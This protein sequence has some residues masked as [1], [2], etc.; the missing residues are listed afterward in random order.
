MAVELEVLWMQLGQ[1]PSS[2]PQDEG[3]S[4]LA[5]ICDVPLMTGISFPKGSKGTAEVYAW[6]GVQPDP[7]QEEGVRKPKEKV[8]RARS[9]AGRAV[10]E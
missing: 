2:P 8:P 3:W 4:M 9:R 5:C 1:E 6:P 10:F 7:T